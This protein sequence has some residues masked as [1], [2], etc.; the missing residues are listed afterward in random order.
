MSEGLQSLSDPP[1][2]SP[3]DVEWLLT[4]SC[5]IIFE[6]RTEGSKAHF[7]VKLY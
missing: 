7:L 4:S 1:C 3:K 6:F 5:H 2:L